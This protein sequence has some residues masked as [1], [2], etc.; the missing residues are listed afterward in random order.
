MRPE[1][2]RRLRSV[3][4]LRQPDLTV[5]MDR[6]HKPH[7]LSAVLRTCDAVG[8]LEAHA[9]VPEGTLRLH[10][11]TS[12][13]TARWVTVHRHPD[14]TSAIRRLRVTGHQV[15]AA[16]PSPDALDFR[17]IDYTG[18]TAILV[19]TE[20]HGVSDEALAASDRHITIPMMGMVRSLNVSVATALILYAAQGQRAAAGLYD[21]PRLSE[22]RFAE[23]LFEWCHPRRAAKLRERGESYPPLDP[24]GGGFRG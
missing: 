19:G 10:R 9:V 22:A 20:L 12:G 2:F 14:A 23:T 21:E 4:S 5:L 16:H 17:E 11:D 24:E 18:P 6:V 7:N 13:G 8:V 15:V 1:R 3:L